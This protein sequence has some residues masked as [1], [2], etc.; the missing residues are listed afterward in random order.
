MW[1]CGF[2][3]AVTSKMLR[4]GSV[5]VPQVT[6]L[7]FFAAGVCLHSNSAAVLFYVLL[8]TL[9]AMRM[10]LAFSVVPSVTERLPRACLIGAL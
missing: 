2:G 4:N 6:G 3:C 1:T 7:H 9:F 10:Y 5:L 8:T